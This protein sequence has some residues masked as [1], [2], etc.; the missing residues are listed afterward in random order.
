MDIDERIN[1]KALYVDEEIKSYLN[2]LDDIF[3]KVG[4]PQNKPK[5]S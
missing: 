3:E 1:E 2:I 5:Q 4:Y